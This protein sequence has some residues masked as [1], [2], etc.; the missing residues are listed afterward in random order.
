MCNT[1][2][3]LRK[4]RQRPTRHRPNPQRNTAALSK[5][6]QNSAALRENTDIFPSGYSLKSSVKHRSNRKNISVPRQKIIP[7]KM[8][9][10]PPVKT[11]KVPL[12]TSAFS[13]RRHTA[14]LRSVFFAT[15]II[16][17]TKEIR[18][19]RNE[20][21]KRSAARRPEFKQ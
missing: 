16:K 14:I 9:T 13:R 15:K 4:R 12:I 8:P 21:S 20:K 17:N 1:G 5:H 19:K 6:Q 7:R 10:E 11:D 3:I 18:E 2:C